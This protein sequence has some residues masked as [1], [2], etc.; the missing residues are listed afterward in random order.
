MMRPSLRGERRRSHALLLDRVGDAVIL[1]GALGHLV[2]EAFDPAPRIVL[3]E[4]GGRHG[5]GV[6]ELHGDDRR[7][8]VLL[9]RE[10]AEEG[11][12]ADPGALGDL[13]GRGLEAALG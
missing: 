11:R 1:A 12:L 13:R 4:T 2:E 5:G 8:Q 9:G 3:L 7:D 10:A 6:L